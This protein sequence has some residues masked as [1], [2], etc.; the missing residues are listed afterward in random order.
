MTQDRH[1]T[2]DELRNPSSTATA[3]VR[4][5]STFV[6]ACSTRPGFRCSVIGTAGT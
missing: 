6:S 5:S 4:R 2:R 1:Q 3:G